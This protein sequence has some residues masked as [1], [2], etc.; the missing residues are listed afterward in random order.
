MKYFN[1]L[2]FNLI[3]VSTVAFSLVDEKKVSALG[4]LSTEVN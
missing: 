1:F 3:L 2:S 4:Y